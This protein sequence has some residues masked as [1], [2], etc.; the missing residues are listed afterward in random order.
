MAGLGGAAQLRPKLIPASVGYVLIPAVLGPIGVRVTDHLLRR[1]EPSPD[2]A[3][4]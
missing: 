4:S 1:H 3:S 2:G